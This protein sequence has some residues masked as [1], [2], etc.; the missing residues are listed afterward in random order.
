MWRCPDKLLEVRMSLKVGLS[1][2]ATNLVLCLTTVNTSSP[3]LSVLSAVLAT[4]LS[5][6]SKYR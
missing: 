5:T 3:S 1:L 6:V 4:A 2:V